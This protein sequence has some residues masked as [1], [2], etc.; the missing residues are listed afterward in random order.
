MNKPKEII[1]FHKVL[2]FQRSLSANPGFETAGAGG[3]DVFADW[4]ETETLGTSTIEQA[5]DSVNTGTYACKLTHGDTL[6]LVSQEHAAISGKLYQLSFYTRG[7]GTNGGRY[8]IRDVTGATNIV[9]IT[10]TGVTGT[11]YVLV[12]KKFVTPA[13]C[14]AL[15]IDLLDGGAGFVYFDDVYVSPVN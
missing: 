10:D 2:T 13:G 7:D 3:T 12:Q 1:L 11:S 15:G 6:V 14:T 9:G 5:I 8:R 4:T